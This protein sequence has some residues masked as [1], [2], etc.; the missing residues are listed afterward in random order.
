MA[1][2]HP[3]RG[4]HHFRELEDGHAGGERVR[5]DVERR[6]Y[7]RPCLRD[8]RGLDGGIPLAAPKVVERAARRSGEGDGVPCGGRGRKGEIASFVALADEL[9]P[10]SFAA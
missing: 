2:D 5:R 1:L 7:I 9:T 3:H 10:P 4:S 8:R 6:S